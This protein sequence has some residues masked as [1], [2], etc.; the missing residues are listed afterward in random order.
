[1]IHPPIY[2]PLIV[3]SSILI[4]EKFNDMLKDQV[5]FISF[6]QFSDNFVQILII[7]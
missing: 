5:R 4:L 3:S 6:E 1:V 7:C 2:K